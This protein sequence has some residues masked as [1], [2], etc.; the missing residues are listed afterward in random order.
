MN[1]ILTRVLQSISNKGNYV[2]FRVKKLALNYI[3]IFICF[4][5]CFAE[6]TVFFFF[7]RGRYNRTFC[8]T[9]QVDCKLLPWYDRRAVLSWLLPREEQSSR[10]VEASLRLPIVVKG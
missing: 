5:L 6:N 2:L 4:F 9:Y 7:E 3:Y 1:W 8:V 10:F